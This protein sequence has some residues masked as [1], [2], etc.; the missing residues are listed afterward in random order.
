M[1][2]AKFWLYMTMVGPQQP[3]GIPH[4]IILAGLCEMHEKDRLSHKQANGTAVLC[5]INIH[6]T[7][8]SIFYDKSVTI[9]VIACSETIV[10]TNFPQVSKLL[11]NKRVF[12]VNAERDVDAY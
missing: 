9:H 4:F 5:T 10:K 7:A 1:S 3:L 11:Q 12:V 2:P 8:T 6:N